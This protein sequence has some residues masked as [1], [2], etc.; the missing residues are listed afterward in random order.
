MEKIGSIVKR[1]LEK[2]ACPC[3]EK[4]YLSLW[5]EVVPRE[6]RRHARVIIREGGVLVLVDNPTTGHTLFLQK[7]K[8]AA[9]F[10]ENNLRVKEITIKQRCQEQKGST[11]LPRKHGRTETRNN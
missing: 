1:V 4:D 5:E 3:E 9:A 6:I 7:D 2:K 10:R 8:I 11:N